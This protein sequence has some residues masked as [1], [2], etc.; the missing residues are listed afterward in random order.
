MRAIAGDSTLAT[1]RNLLRRPETSPFSGFVGTFMARDALSLAATYLDL[2]RGHVVL[3]PAYLCKEVLRPF[4]GRSRLLFY[5]VADDLS[6]DPGTVKAVLARERV[7]LL[8]V[9][10]Y[11]GFLQPRREEISSLCSEHGTVLLEDCAHSLLTGGSGEC[12]DLSVVSY[13]KLLPVFD[14]G[15]LRIRRKRTGFTV[16]YHPRLYSDALSLLATGKALAR[17][18][19]AALSRA[20]VA[21][22]RG[23]LAAKEHDGAPRRFL[24]L[25]WFAF[26]GVGNA[27]VDD[28]IRRRRLDY[29]FWDELVRRSSDMTPVMNAI[30]EGV[31]PL[32]FPVTSSQ[33]DSLRDGLKGAGVPVTVHWALPPG[34]GDECP[35]SQRLSRRMMTLPLYPELTARIKERAAET[36]S[37]GRSL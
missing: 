7:R 14:G 22:R 12:G 28:I 4:A 30:G 27:P 16:P 31:C 13:R 3:L 35:N 32:G 1:L 24:P 8:L 19:S 11:F 29:E 37:R 15:G 17:F 26:N 9:I 10:N 18:R 21:D 23:T 33:R 5:D 6:V 2:T 34:V 20:G 36:L 25:S